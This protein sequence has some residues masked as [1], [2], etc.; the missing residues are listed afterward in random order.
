M[1]STT[2]SMT[3]GTELRAC[4]CLWRTRRLWSALGKPSRGDRRVPRLF[5]LDRL[6]GAREDSWAIRRTIRL[7]GTGLAQFAGEAVAPVSGC[8]QH[9]AAL[10]VWWMEKLC[11]G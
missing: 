2:S 3:R 6:G 1:G 9:S 4:G 11:G 10:V 8:E 7:P 5:S